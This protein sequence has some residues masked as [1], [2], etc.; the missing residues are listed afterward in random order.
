MTKA[1]DNARAHVKD[2]EMRA[3]RKIKR[4]QSKGIRTSG[5][6][7]FRDVDPSNTRALKSYAR[8]LEQFISRSTRFVAGRDGTPIPYSAYR[9]YKRI[10]TRWNVEHDRYWKKFAEHPFL[11]AYGESDTTLGMRSAMSHV[12]GLPFGGID[13]KRE[14]LP[15][16]IRGVEDLHKRMQI[17]KRELSPSY[18]RKRI[19]QLRKNLLE[20][21]ATFNDPRIPNMIKKLSN[22]QLFALQ[23]FTNF[24]PLY[25]RYINTDKDNVLGAQADAMDDDMQKE[26]MILTIQQVQNQY[27]KKSAKKR[28]ENKPYDREEAWKSGAKRITISKAD[29]SALKYDYIAAI[30]HNRTD[31]ISAIGAALKH[32]SHT[33]SP[34]GGFKVSSRTY[35]ELYRE[36]LGYD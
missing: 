35:Y 9:E 13:Y 15:E 31:E 6:A 11:T 29:I 22:E 30:N 17:L 33:K 27:P 12:K 19:T 10:E 8:D 2:A 3:R 25:Y 20:H 1:N 28:R 21:A 32:A 16:Q 18:Q 14:L 23:N 34:S 4:L 26:H 7:P 24:V 5:I 36:V